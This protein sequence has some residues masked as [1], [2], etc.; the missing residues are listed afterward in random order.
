[1]S[2]LDRTV[3]MRDAARNEVYKVE[4]KV[5]FCTAVAHGVMSKDVSGTGDTCGCHAD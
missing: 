5:T 2:T 4:R 3:Q 1:M